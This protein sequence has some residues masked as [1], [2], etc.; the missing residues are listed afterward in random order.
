VLSDEK[1]AVNHMQLGHP[2]LSSMT[3][4]QA[5]QDQPKNRSLLLVYIVCTN[6]ICAT[7][8]YSVMSLTEKITKKHFFSLEK[9]VSCTLIELP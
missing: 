5:H 4:V 6:W 3:K 9:T 8:C 2:Y 1:L 7:F